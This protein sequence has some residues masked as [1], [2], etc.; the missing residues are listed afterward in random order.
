ML[1]SVPRPPAPGKEASEGRLGAMTTGDGTALSE[2]RAFFGPRAAAWEDR[3]PATTRVSRRRWPPWRPHEGGVALDVGCGTGRALPLLRAAVGAGGRRHGLDAT[4]EM[5]G[6]GGG[7]NRQDVAALVLGDAVH[8][9]LAEASVDAVFTAGLL[10]RLPDAGAGLVE[11]AGSRY[12]KAGWP[13][14]IPSAGPLC[15]PGTAARP[16]TTIR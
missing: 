6:Q 10:P 11:L 3:F 13:S 7:R 8:L 1:A 9:P 2:T 12:P 4:P 5:L 15:G 16:R 14:S